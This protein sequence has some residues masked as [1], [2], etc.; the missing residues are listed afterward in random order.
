M[1][2]YYRI[3][4]QQPATHTKAAKNWV[5]TPE[6][7][8]VMSAD[9]SLTKEHKK[10]STLTL[11]LWDERSNQQ[12][13]PIANSLPD[14]AFANVPLQLYLSKPSEGQSA[15]KL[16]FD[17]K[18]TQLS[19]GW[20]GPSHTT[21]V[22]HDKSI[23]MRRAAAYRTIKNKTSVQLATAISKEYGLET[24]TSELVGVTLTTRLIDMGLGSVGLGSFSDW[25]HITRAL[26]VDGLEMYVVGNKLKIRKLAQIRYPHTFRPEDDLVIEFQPQINHV[27]GPGA[28]GQSKVPIP[29]GSKGTNLAVTGTKK[30]ETDAEGADATTH[31]TIP[32][33]QSSSGAAVHTEGLG[34]N[35]SPA[36][37]KRKRKDEA[38]LVVWALPDIGLQHL[39]SISGWGGKFDGDWHIKALKHS[40]A[41]RTPATSSLTL[42]REPSSAS[43]KQ[44]GIQPGGT[45]T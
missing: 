40:I 5:W 33:S 3:T 8:I 22:A 23:D 19:C 24:D 45:S 31:R 10:I 7:D 4:V 30:I 16:V 15:S 20:P 32:Q 36:D 17:G 13:W 14:P 1:S 42:T 25:H 11:Q 21:I 29:G 39:I 37:Q 26:A 41:G 12:L 2:Q 34:D 43:Q 18:I 27:S 35:K 6:S 28:G 38:T 44:I 9:V